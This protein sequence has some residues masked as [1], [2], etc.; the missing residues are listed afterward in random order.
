MQH[1]AHA[2][3]HGVGQQRHEQRPAHTH[4][5]EAQGG[6]QER[7]NGVVMETS[8]HV[9]HHVGAKRKLGVASRHEHSERAARGWEAQVPERGACMHSLSHGRHTGKAHVDAATS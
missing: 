7:L 2:L 4:D 5:T 3:L 6:L 8:R 9:V 1:G